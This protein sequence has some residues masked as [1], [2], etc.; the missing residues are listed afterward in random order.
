MNNLNKIKEPKRKHKFTIRL[1]IIIGLLSILNFFYWFLKPELIENKL[2]F[3]FLAAVLIFGSLRIVFLWYHYWNIAIPV[4]VNSKKQFSV[5]ILTT[6]FPGEPYDMVIATL[7]AIKKINHSH[8]VTTYLC[9]EA[10]DDYLKKFCADNDIVHVTRDNRINAKAGNIN[11]ALKQATGEI[12]L[13]LDPDHVP[14]PNFLEETIPYFEDEQVGYVQSVQAY[15]NYN[16]SKVALAAAQQTFHFYGPVMMC[17]NA[18]GT[19][20]A[21]GA[22]CIFRRKALDSI[23]GHAPGLSEDMHTA[24]Q[25]HA[26]GWKSTYVPKVLTRGLTPATLTAYYKQ[27]LKWSRGTLD[28][29][30]SVYPKLFKNFTWRQKLHYGLLPIHYLSGIFFLIGFLI[31][32][33]SL[34]NASLPWKGNIINFGLIYTPVF[35]C[36]IGIHIYVQRW[37]LH[38]SERGLHFL[39]GILMICTWWIYLVGFI[40]TVIGK[41]VPYLPTPKN[42]EGV[43]SFKLLIPNLVVALVSI[44]AIIYGLSIDFTPFTI[45]MA[46]FAAINAFFMLYTFRFAYDKPLAENAALQNYDK[47]YLKNIKNKFFKFFNKSVISIVVLVALTCGSLQY[48]GDY[49][50]WKGVSPEIKVKNKIRYLGTFTPK[51]DNGLTDLKELQKSIRF[52]EGEFDIISLYLAWDEDIESNFP[53]TLIDSIYQQKSTPLITW[54]PWLNSFASN[55]NTD[56]KN[57][58]EQIEQG[59]FDE[60]IYRFSK[61]L[62]NLNRPVFIRF[63]HEFDNPFYPWYVEGE[64]DSESFKIAWIHIYEIFKNVRADNVIWIWNPWK[65]ENVKDYY[66]GSDYVDWIGV[67]VLNYGSLNKDGKN[68]DFIDLY[69]PF[70]E[71]FKKLPATPVIIAEFGSLKDP[72]SAEVQEKWIDSAFQNIENEFDEIKSVVYFNSKVDNNLPQGES[73]SIYLDWTVSS[74]QTSIN[75]FNSKKVP[76]YVLQPFKNKSNKIKEYENNTNSEPVNYT[77]GVNLKKGHNW[78]KDYHVLTRNNLVSD[79]EKLSKLGIKTVN[80]LGNSVYDY[81]VL[82]VSKAKGIDISYSFWV[83]ENLDF[84]LDTLKTTALKKEIVNKVRSLKDNKQIFRWHIKNDVLYLQKD[85]YQKPELLYQNEAYALWIKDLLAQIKKIDSKRL[86]VLDFE[87][88]KQTKYHINYILN[89]VKNIDI[90]GLVAE[91][92]E[93]LEDVIGFLKKINKPFV[94]SDIDIKTIRNHK[95]IEKKIPFYIRQWQDE[96][97]S[98]HLNFN[99]LIDRKGRYKAEYSEFL[100]LVGKKKLVDNDDVFNI[101]K[102]SRYIFD[103]QKY[104]YHALVFNR[105]SDSWDF[106]SKYKDL[107]YEWSLIKCDEFGNYL[108]INE[109]GETSELVLKVPKIYHLYRLRLAIIKNDNIIASIV[110]ELNT[111]IL[112]LDDINKD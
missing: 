79:F 3:W 90:I 58:Y 73:S 71:E 26:K 48:Y 53:K 38:K 16:E 61:V 87:V 49:I 11:N 107:K 101:L 50:K 43:T 59:E 22:N 104:V 20:N 52:K 80:Y 1:L 82:N 108:A 46:C 23:G 27:Q 44:F 18:Y 4:K 17:M 106:A 100:T 8:T 83:P 93:D 12:T 111:P 35:A 5:D 92:D 47:P 88:N 110:T 55:K 66:P 13:I 98:N 19:V 15:Y 30:T 96:H 74:E 77:M 89:Y 9:D 56:D 28:L 95:I 78:D 10:N 75:L 97:E 81:N 68:H 45:L 29:L 6:Y 2:L 24:M 37:L 85:F 112:E 91:Y 76:N 54:E 42:S 62:K 84:V 72:K 21:I 105:D 33:I 14:F 40:Y 57:L 32:I 39:G 70:H 103:G 99:G 102:P 86:V 34:L 63:A 94:L 36:L 64:E 65:A 7:K 67:N 25:L 51:F 69:S 31:P 41:K 60:Y 109:I